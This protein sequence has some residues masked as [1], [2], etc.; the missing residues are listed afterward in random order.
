MRRTLT[1]I[2]FRDDACRVI[3]DLNARDT[4]NP[5]VIRVVNKNL[6]IRSVLTIGRVEHRYEVDMTQHNR[7]TT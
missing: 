6:I 7:S 4:Y 2:W 3:I 5:A 1:E